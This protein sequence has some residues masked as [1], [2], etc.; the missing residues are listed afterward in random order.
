MNLISYTRKT[1]RGA[2]SGLSGLLTLVGTT[3]F[4]VTLGGCSPDR[5]KSTTA[6]ADTSEVVRVTG[7]IESARSA[8]FG[9]PVV[10]NIWQYTISFMAPEGRKVKAGTPILKFD[11]QELM[12]RLRDKSNA[13][14]EKQKQLEKQEIVAREVVAELKLKRQ[15]AMADLDKARLKA[16][17]PVVLLASRDY[18]EYKL[19]LKQA[20]LTLELR[21]EELQKEQRVQDTEITILK[22]EIAVLESEVAQVQASVESMTIKAAGEG[23]VIYTVDRRNNKQE[24]GDNVWMGRRV[25]ELPD[26]S[27]LQVQLEVPER[28]SARIAIGQTVKFVVDAVPEEQFFGEI[29]ELASVIRSKSRSQPARVF[30][31]TVSMQNPNLT[32]MRPG[33]SVSAEIYLQ[34]GSRSSK[35][36]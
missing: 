10:P 36:P 20:E 29:I 30:D 22:R 33:M 35:G 34:K 21:R 25:M 7:E 1:G 6:Q 23:V 12:T 24:V 27:Q 11:P 9:P 28:E 14:N 4:T 18:R 16:D 19:V 13:M 2:V 5:N 8:F 26:L 3:I 32:I 17:I 31:A 15:E